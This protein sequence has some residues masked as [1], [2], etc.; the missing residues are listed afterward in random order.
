[1]DGGNGHL[2]W[3]KINPEGDIIVECSTLDNLIPD[4]M[5]FPDFI[6]MDVEGYEYKLIKH[7]TR[8]LKSC[9][10]L[11]I[12]IH[13]YLIDKFYN[14]NWFEI[15]YYLREQG[16]EPFYVVKEFGSYH[17]QG[18]ECDDKSFCDVL[19]CLGIITRIEYSTIKDYTCGMGV[20]FRRKK[21]D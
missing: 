21:G 1:M 17:E 9:R 18:M 4:V 19:A 8:S 5:P 20:F 14:G 2:N 12:E 16:F 10:Y 15:W 3:S 7:F 13:P 11:F 6:R